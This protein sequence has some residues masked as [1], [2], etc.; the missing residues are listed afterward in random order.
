MKKSRQCKARRIILL[1]SRR[2]ASKIFKVN[3][4][5]MPLSKFDDDDFCER[6]RELYERKFKIPDRL[7]KAY[8]LAS[9]VR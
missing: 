2:M 8:D 6:V 4:R 1:S 3:P 7:V 5:A 9:L